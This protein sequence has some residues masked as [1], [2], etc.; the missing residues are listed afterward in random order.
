MN[1]LWFVQTNKNKL[2]NWWNWWNSSITSPINIYNLKQ[3]KCLCLCI[4]FDLLTLQQ[5][6]FE[7]LGVLIGN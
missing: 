6:Y 1:E 5:I 4:T 2:I 3:I 7:C